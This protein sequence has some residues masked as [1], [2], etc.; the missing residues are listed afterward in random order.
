[1]EVNSTAAQKNGILTVANLMCIAA[2]TAPK[3]RGIDNIIT[4]ILTD[5]EIEE[6]SAKMVEIANTG[7]RT[8]TFLRD[9]EC[10][11]KAAAIVLIGTKISAI[12]LDCGFCGFEN[13]KKCGELKGVCAYNSGDLGIAIGSA[14]SI[15]ADNRVDNR[16]MFSA[17]YTAVKNKLIDKD[18]KIAF[19]IPLDASCKNIFFERK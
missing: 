1:M 15:A 17:G 14:V 9:A 16:I 3:A 2:R 8:N 4:I 18:V 12:G 10:V 5:K 19:G 11:K 13:C 7:Y 6:L